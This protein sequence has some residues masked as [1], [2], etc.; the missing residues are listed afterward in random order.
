MASSVSGQ[1]ES[2]PQVKFIIKSTKFYKNNANPQ[3]AEA[4]PALWLATRAG[5]MEPRSGLPALSGRKTS[6]KAI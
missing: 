3:I 5:K 4:N 6:P 2:N 1:D